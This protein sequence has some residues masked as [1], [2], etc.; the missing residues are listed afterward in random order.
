M[1]NGQLIEPE[2][3]LI[4]SAKAK[5]EEAQ[6]LHPQK[7]GEGLS[8]WTCR[9]TQLLTANDPPEVFLDAARQLIE[10]YGVELIAERMRAIGDD[11]FAAGSFPAAAY[12][13]TA[14]IEKHDPEV[15]DSAQLMHCHVNRAAALLKLGQT[16]AAVADA[17]LALSIAEGCYA[18]KTQRKAYLRRA[19]ALFKLGKLD[20]A[21]ADAEK[22]GEGDAAAETLLEKIAEARATGGTVV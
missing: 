8:D 7:P 13:Y 9:L 5:L 6:Q 22:L 18:P 17:D 19:Q 21:E 2:R 20:Q 1:V 14:G 16:E 12:C 15:G 11:H 3:F 10:A 4:P